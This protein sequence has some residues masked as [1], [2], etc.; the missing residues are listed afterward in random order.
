MK[1][2]L[3]ISSYFIL[4][5]LLLSCK[6]IYKEPQKP[7]PIKISKKVYFYQQP[8]L[9]LLIEENNDVEKNTLTFSVLN[10]EHTN[11]DSIILNIDIF[12]ADTPNYENLQYS[13]SLKF[14][15]VKAN[16]YS[17]KIIYEISA[18]FQLNVNRISSNLQ[19]IKPFTNNILANAYRGIYKLFN[20]DSSLYSNNFVFGYINADGSSVFY[21]KD[22]KYKQINAIFTDSLIESGNISNNNFLIPT[23]PVYF[24]N[25][26]D[27]SFQFSIEVDSNAQ[28]DFD[29]LHLNLHKL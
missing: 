19:M 16:S 21:L 8:V 3:P 12:D 18:P 11:Y 27:K 14:S 15:N 6:N 10:L 1:N 25:I 13:Y 9:E 4:C 23:T 2:R 26:A 7:S 28:T 22:E 20:A 17:N 24:S 5:F 29:F